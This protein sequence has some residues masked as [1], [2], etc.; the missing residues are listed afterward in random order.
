MFVAGQFLIYP[1]EITSGKI[2]FSLDT[3]A[4]IHIR[5]SKLRDLLKFVR[6][7]YPLNACTITIRHHAISIFMYCVLKY[8]I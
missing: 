4:Y 2:F 1:T 7:N 8:K 6:C 3:I 5:K